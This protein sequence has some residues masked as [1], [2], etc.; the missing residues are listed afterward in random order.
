MMI[1]QLL[2][3]ATVAAS[4][5]PFALSPASARPVAADGHYEWQTA[6]QQGPRTPL[7]AP[8]RVS[9]PAGATANVAMN[10]HFERR[11]VVRPGPRA[12]PSVAQ[13]VWVADPASAD[14]QS[15]A[16]TRHAN[17]PAPIG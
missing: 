13:R 12:L 9:I 1:K 16:L 2:L 17:P 4:L 7:Q 10:G 11:T 15:A 6:R 14:Q 8:V 3:A 5:S